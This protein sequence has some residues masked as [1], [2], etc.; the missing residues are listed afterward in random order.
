MFNTIFAN[1][2]AGKPGQ[3]G[4]QTASARSTP[5]IFEPME[6]RV[7]LNGAVLA[8]SISSVTVPAYLN[9]ES[10]PA[11][12][13][14]L[15]AQQAPGTVK[16]LCYDDTPAP[17]DPGSDPSAGDPSS[18]PSTDPSSDP[19]TA[20]AT[21]P[22]TQLSPDPSTQPAPSTE[23]STE[24]G[25]APSTE[26]ETEP[27]TEPSTEPEAPPEVSCEFPVEPIV[28]T[29]QT[30]TS[31]TA[32][33]S[34][35]TAGD[36][37]TLTANV[38]YITTNG[39]VPEG[40]VTFYDGK[41]ALGT[42]DLADD[43]TATLTTTTLGAGVH[44]VYAAFSAANDFDDSTSSA[45]RVTVME[46]SIADG[47]RYIDQLYRDLLHRDVDPVGD[48]TW[49][50]D[51]QNGGTFQAVAMAI[52][53][54]REYESNLVDSFYVSYLGRHAEPAGLNAW[55]NQ[56]QGG[57]NAE[58]IRAGI[59]GSNEYFTDVGGSNAAYVTALYQ[60]FLGRSPDATGFAYW[61]QQL[62]DGLHTRAEV[63]LGISDSE[64]NRADT[65]TS[66]YETF[67]HRGP[68][69]PGLAHW[70]QLLANGVSQ[71]QIVTAFV[72]APEYLA[73]HGIA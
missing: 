66:F 29:G 63:S 60:G 33:A 47:Q 8:S 44:K 10:P 59:L 40:I 35:I 2:F 42:S 43:Q 21:D 1:L 69:E 57:L 41:Q 67:L 16:V 72:T 19:S 5:V 62:G 58:Q 68:D 26:P 51:L 49:N 6:S 61:T 11:Q 22:T 56:M 15:D 65:V 37:L 24:P 13:A 38:G 7:L 54:S 52:T 55:V 23:P 53:N 34:L 64:E 31:I 4:R 45:V 36:S 46:H 71:S 73:I 48:A 50:A 30:S 39:D 28:T 27:A 25:T 12:H 18:D 9:L 70:G 14:P 32:S 3:R 20:P 17:A